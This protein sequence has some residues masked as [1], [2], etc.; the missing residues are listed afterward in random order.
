MRRKPSKEPFT[1]FEVDQPRLMLVDI[2]ASVREIVDIDVTGLQI[3]IVVQAK[4][5][6]LPDD[7][8]G[9]ILLR[10]EAIAT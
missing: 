10:H 3:K 8:F 1:E 7:T 6:K 9:K 2:P 4:F 5:Y